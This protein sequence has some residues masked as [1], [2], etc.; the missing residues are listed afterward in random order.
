MDTFNPKTAKNPQHAARWIQIYASMTPDEMQTIGK[1]IARAR[2]M[3]EDFIR[4]RGLSQEDQTDWVQL[5][6]DICVTHADRRLKLMQLLLCDESDFKQE[7]YAIHHS[8]NRVDLRF[9]DGVRLR[10][11]EKNPGVIPN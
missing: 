2:R 6:M 3:L 1:I 4:E 9:P 7:I 10:F 5:S 11:A 8:V